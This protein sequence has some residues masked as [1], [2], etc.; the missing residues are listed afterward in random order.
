MG[1]KNK[2][3]KRQELIVFARTPQKNARKV[4]TNQKPA[5]VFY[6]SGIFFGGP[7]KNDQLLAFFVFCFLLP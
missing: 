2:N 4:K 5:S 3:K 7:Q 6:S 1:A